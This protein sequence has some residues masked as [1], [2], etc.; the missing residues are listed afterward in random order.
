MK[1][2][3]NMF[4]FH[5]FFGRKP[6]DHDFFKD[7][8]NEVKHE[9]QVHDMANHKATHGKKNHIPHHGEDYRKDMMNHSHEE[10][11]SRGSQFIDKIKTWAHGDSWRRGSGKK[12]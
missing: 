8:L 2:W 12:K 10:K 3:R 4:P 1:N 11:L 7:K 6:K 9:H 5:Y